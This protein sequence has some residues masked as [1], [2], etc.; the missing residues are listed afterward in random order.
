VTRAHATTV[1]PSTP[2]ADLAP[3]HTVHRELDAL[4]AEDAVATG[5]LLLDVREPDEFA[6]GHAPAA[7]SVPLGELGGRLDELAGTATV[8]CVCRSGSRSAAAAE[9]L[10][11]AGYDA[12]NL[13]GGMIAWS[14][15]GLPIVS[16]T[17]GA[18][19]VR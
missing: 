16:S 19:E 14:Q 8:V 1:S 18:G 17:G 9:A 3:G 11:A 6:A 5:A 10:T 7:K 2:Q 13:V 4:D 12:I 15:E